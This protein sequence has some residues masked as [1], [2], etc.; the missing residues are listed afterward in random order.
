[1]GIGI[2]PSG[3]AHS[4]RLAADLKALGIAAL[5]LLDAPRSSQPLLVDFAHALG[6]MYV[7]EGSTLGSQVILPHLIDVLGDEIANAHSFFLG[8]GTRT[9][10]FW[11]AFRISID[12]YGAQHPDKKA[13]V[14]SGAKSAF[15]AISA[16]MQP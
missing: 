6:V 1:M 10:A 16:W 7:V 3:C 11:S 13:D 4:L 8:R 14:I 2:E 15:R 12:R 5:D 9:G